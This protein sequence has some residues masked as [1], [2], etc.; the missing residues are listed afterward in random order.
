[1]RLNGAAFP[2][3]F[4][5]DFFLSPEFEEVRRLTAELAAVGDPPFRLRENGT[6]AE[7]A[8]LEEAVR[9]IVERARRG[10]TIQRYKGLG[11]MNPE[12]L[13]ETTMDPER[14]TLLQVRI[15]D[16]PEADM[17][18][19]TLMG[20]EVE[21]RRRFIEENALNVRRLDI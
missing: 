6:V 10:M 4:D 21:P 19:S 16:L 8:S 13:W 18:F 11:E 12:Q 5:L 14:R 1:M 3:V 7:A 15:E 20:D 9:R 2:G 17:I